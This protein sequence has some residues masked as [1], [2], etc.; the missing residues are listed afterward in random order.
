MHVLPSYHWVLLV[1]V[2]NV[3]HGVGR[4]QPT[5]VQEVGRLD[6]GVAHT[7]T[8]QARHLEAEWSSEQ[9]DNAI[10]VCV[11]EG[12]REKERDSY[13]EIQTDGGSSPINTVGS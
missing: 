8:T 4:E 9:N 7:H 11:W 3:G 12:N 2:E 1:T 5:G 13:I 6:G 10:S